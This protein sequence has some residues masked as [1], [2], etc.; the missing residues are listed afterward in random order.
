MVGGQCPK[1]PQIP[2]RQSRASLR[3]LKQPAFANLITRAACLQ[4]ALSSSLKALDNREPYSPAFYPLAACPR[5]RFS[6]EPL[7]QRI[8]RMRAGCWLRLVWSVEIARKRTA[9]LREFFRSPSR[10]SFSRALASSLK[11]LAISIFWRSGDHRRLIAASQFVAF[12]GKCGERVY[13]LC[14]PHLPTHP[15][16]L[17]TAPWGGARSAG[18]VREPKA[19]S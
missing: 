19:R 8:S 9:N 15:P 17:I 12:T 6:F 1:K 14:T 18:G 10:T 11:A 16:I 4:P 3:L 7:A 13:L 5:V 2:A